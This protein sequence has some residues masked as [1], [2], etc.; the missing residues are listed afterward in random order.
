MNSWSFPIKR[1][2]LGSLWLIMAIGM[3]GCQ[4]SS[5]PCF[6]GTPITISSTTDTT[7]PVSVGM[8]AHS[9]REPKLLTVTATSGPAQAKVRRN[10]VITL[11]VS[12][13]DPEGIKDIQI[14]VEETWDFNGTHEGPTLSQS[15][16]QSNPDNTAPGGTGCSTRLTTFNLD[17]E[18]RSKKATYY[19]IKTWAQAVN[20]SGTALK[21]DALT[22]EY[23]E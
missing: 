11:A 1:S 5:S 14:W 4:P 21:T 22:L 18:Q 3:S 12:G 10:D 6:T 17:I 19:R 13:T 7:A 9:P 2:Q 8:D 23:P 16:I 15:P 20:F